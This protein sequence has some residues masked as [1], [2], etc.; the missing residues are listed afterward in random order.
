MHLFLVATVVSFHTALLVPNYRSPNYV[1]QPRNKI[2]RKNVE[3]TYLS[4]CYAINPILHSRM[5][6]IPLPII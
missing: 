5:V 1:I 6:K 3:L 2:Y 4:C